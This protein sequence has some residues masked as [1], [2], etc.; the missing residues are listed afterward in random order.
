MR[1]SIL[2]LIALFV[3]VLP[4]FAGAQEGGQEFRSSVQ[5]PAKFLCGYSS[6]GDSRLGVVQG[7]YNT[8]VNILASRNNTV[9]AIRATMV[10]SDLEIEDQ[11]SQFSERIELDQDEA[12]GVLCSDIKRGLF[13]VGG[14]GGEGA[15]GFMD[16][17]VTIFSN[18]S[19]T[20]TAVVT[21]EN[22]GGAPS[23]QI[24]TVSERR[25]GYRVRPGLG[26]PR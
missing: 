4:Q 9:L 26:E 19:L 20:V 18:K 7:H 21:G 17:F 5:Y 24:I 11:I 8:I 3:V 22:E 14:G 13:E 25:G 10:R 6:G 12:I 2:G 15:Q 1:K 23:I 16:G